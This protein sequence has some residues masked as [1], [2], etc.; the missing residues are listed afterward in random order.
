MAREIKTLKVSDLKLN[1]R[2]PRSFKKNKIEELML[3]LESFKKMLEVRPI[4]VNSNMEILGGNARLVAIKKLKWKEVPVMVVED[5]SGQEQDEFMIKDNVSFGDWDWEKLTK[6][7]EWDTGLIQEWGLEIPDEFKPQ[8]T[9]PKKDDV[10]EE[11]ETTSS[12]LARHKTQVAKP[13]DVWILGKHR[14]AC[15]D[16]RDAVII[17]RLMRHEK[18]MCVVTDPPYNVNYDPEMRESYFSPERLANKLGKI[19][20]DIMSPDE[21]HKFMVEVYTSINNCLIDGGGIYIFHADTEGH[22]FRNAFKEM[23]WKLASCLIWYKTVLCFGRSDYHWMHEPIL[24][25]WKL[26]AARNWHGDR[27][28]TTVFQFPTD[29]YNKG[30]SDTDGY[31]HPTQKPTNVLRY[32]MGNSMPKEAGIVLDLFLGSGS[33]L[34][35]AQQTFRACYGTEL[36]PKFVDVII[37]RWENY[38]SED[39]VHE[40]TG[41]TYKQL[42]GELENG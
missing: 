31:V 28:Q 25:G 6:S 18:A 36:D 8:N 26:G 12:I 13:G 39:A 22:H 40:S 2:N 38:T 19:K 21:F 33:T 7:G 14:V 9:P 4:V 5:F 15:G 10:R 24:Y 29:H 27:K 17:E 20:N 23:P 41:K 1:P 42:K 16:C 30:E 37:E 3:S 35:A 11:A 34:I 32:L